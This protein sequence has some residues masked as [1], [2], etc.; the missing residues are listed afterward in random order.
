MDKKCENCGKVIRDETKP[1]PFCLP[2][3]RLNETH[4]GQEASAQAG[5]TVP[6]D[7]ED[8]LKRSTRINR[9]FMAVMSWIIF[10][11]GTFF[12]LVYYGSEGL[13]SSY[14]LISIFFVLLG[15]SGIISRKFIFKK[16]SKK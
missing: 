16:R 9:M 4:F 15:A 11:L 1:C 5:G 14:T 7:E 2:D 10:L 3:G 12:F 13:T 6:M 8:V